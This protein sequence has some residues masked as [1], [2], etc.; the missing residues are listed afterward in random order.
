MKKVLVLGSAGMLGHQ[1]S[2][3]F[4]RNSKYNVVET[5]FQQSN[6][7]DAIVIDVTKQIEV[8]KLILTEKPDVII[9][10][11]GVLIKGSNSNQANAIYINSYFPHQLSELSRKV[12]ARLIHI[13]TDCVFSGEKGGYIETDYKDAKDT[14]GKTKGLGELIN[15]EDLTIRTSIIGPE[16]KENGEGLLHWFLNQSE[17]IN[18]YTNAL[19]AGV[20][21]FQLAKV[22]LEF[23]EKDI[24]GL[25]QVTNSESIN[26]YDLLNLFNKYSKKGLKV[27][28]FKAPKT[29]DKSF[30]DTQNL[31]SPIPSYEQMIKEMFENINEYSERYSHYKI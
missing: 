23:E 24:K 7:S 31:I 22:I 20:T 9:N 2:N 25:Y 17:A 3:L 28:P 15:N 29:V 5:S 13:S 4:R 1:V 10:C 26:K 21:T 27:S 11:I 19:W 18:G 8:E 30:L 16:L 6:N 14:Y 12:S